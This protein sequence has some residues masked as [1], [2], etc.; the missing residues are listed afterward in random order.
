MANFKD[1]D[2]CL[3]VAIGLA[4]LAI[5]FIISICC[6]CSRISLAV[7]VIKASAR[8]MTDNPRIVLVPVV[9]F[10]VSSVFFALWMTVALYLYSSGGVSN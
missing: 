1:K 7:Q 5:T 9:S 10:V 6:M 4:V 2:T 3:F 8:F